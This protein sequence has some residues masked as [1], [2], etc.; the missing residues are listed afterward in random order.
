[1]THPHFGCPLTLFRCTPSRFRSTPSHF[2]YPMSYFGCTPSHIGTPTLEFRLTSA[3]IGSPRS[4]FGSPI[5]DIIV[6]I[7][8][9]KIRKFRFG[10]ENPDIFAQ[11][12]N[13]E[14]H[15][16]ILPM[17]GGVLR[18]PTCQVLIS[19]FRDRKPKFGFAAQIICLFGRNFTFRSPALPLCT[20][21]F[22]FG[23]PIL[24]FGSCLLPWKIESRLVV[25][26]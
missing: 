4:G 22:A 20:G 25:P 9:L 24:R 17:G 10:G 2:I 1:M 3:E 19:K 5:F 21:I 8:Q 15:K 23:S 13:F 11:K 6:P 26:R 18:N 7:S 14:A 16:G 12:F